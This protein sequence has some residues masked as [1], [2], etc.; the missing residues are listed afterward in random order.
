[1]TPVEPPR[2]GRNERHNRRHLGRMFGRRVPRE[3]EEPGVRAAGDPCPEGTRQPA[4]SREKSRESSTHSA[5]DAK[6]MR[7]A[8]RFLAEPGPNQN[9]L[10]HSGRRQ[11]FV[12]VQRS[13]DSHTGRTGA[14][15][16]VPGPRG[17]HISL[18]SLRPVKAVRGTR[19]DSDHRLGWSRNR[20]AESGPRIL[21][22]VPIRFPAS[23]LALASLARARRYDITV[24]RDAASSA[25]KSCSSQALISSI[26]SGSH[27]L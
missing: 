24:S 9:W 8:A 27:A 18:V 3:K 13:A 19:E 2:H 15:S 5:W 10:H 25:V 22:F 16:E 20:G 23:A 14:P 11:K 6:M 26:L 1:M 4:D 17:S 7:A 21:V 12:I